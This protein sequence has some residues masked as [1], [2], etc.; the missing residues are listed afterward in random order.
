M[1]PKTF[2]WG[3]PWRL[4]FIFTVLLAGGIVASSPVWLGLLGMHMQEASTGVQAHEG[5]SVWGVLPWLG[6]VTLPIY[7]LVAALTVKVCLILLAIDLFRK[8]KAH[9]S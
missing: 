4:V 6:M 7:V 2:L 1:P 8:F 9:R 5:N 3:R